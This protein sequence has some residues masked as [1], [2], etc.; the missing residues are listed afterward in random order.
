MGAK[1]WF[2][3]F[4]IVVLLICGASVVLVPIPASAAQSGWA[5]ITPGGSTIC[6]RGTP[7]SFYV[8][9]GDPSRLLIYFQG[10]GM[11]WDANTCA[12]NSGLFD[13][14][15]A[16]EDPVSY[17]AGIFA[18]SPEN[19][20]ANHTA[21]FVA[22]CTGD[23]HVG[24]SVQQYAD[25]LT[26]YHNGFNNAAAALRWTV[27]NYP[28]ASEVVIS[29]CSAGA[30]ASI[31]Y[32]PAIARR[33]SGARITQLGDS[34]AGALPPSWGGLNVWNAFAHSPSGQRAA[35][36][37]N[38]SLYAEAASRYPRAV[39]AQYTTIGDEVQQF[40]K[41]PDGRLELLGDI[42]ASF[43]ALETRT[44]FRS[45]LAPGGEHCITPTPRFYTEI[46][47]GVRFVDWFAALINRGEAANVG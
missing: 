23:L 37:F 36:E 15:T 40:Y 18:S 8:R 17:G 27:S 31:Y 35:N 25:D 21:V 10:G 2:R 22:Y 5:A 1:I 29:G 20:V 28:A 26:I 7:Y 16:P 14:N 30:Y 43:D 32:A 6:A 41:R 12:A 46:V 19:P 44:N 24:D 38:T 4:M 34:G 13:E 45:Y 9:Q 3:A 39:F 11:C 33:Y 42:A 47:D